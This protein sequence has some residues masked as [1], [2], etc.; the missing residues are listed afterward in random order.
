MR[1][2][3]GGSGFT[4]IRTEGGLVP[5][6]LL[7]RIAAGDPDLEAIAAAAYHLA[8]GER[9]NEAINRSWSRLTGAWA[10][11]RAELA[12]LP[13]GEPATGT[14]RQGWSLL[15]FQELG[16]GQLQPEKTVEL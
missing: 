1:A 6:E 2:R 15:L 12:R 11:F 5:P 16:Y 10:N 3:D 7:A 8:A 4:T 14:T 13:E 9:R